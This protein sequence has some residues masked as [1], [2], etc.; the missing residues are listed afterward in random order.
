LST[1]TLARILDQTLLCGA[2]MM[3]HQK[4]DSDRP[5]GSAALSID[6]EW[7]IHPADVKQLV[8]DG[9][10]VLLDVR[11]PGEWE[12]ARI[13]GAILLP[14]SELPHRLHEIMHH[15]SKPVIVH[16]HHGM[17]SL[18]AVKWLRQQGFI[19]A[20]SMAAGIDGWSLWIDPTVP[21]Y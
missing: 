13:P 3:A 12:V 15:Q 16:C 20:K 4:P 14:L 19:H 7:E 21:R 11:T 6:P 10:V 8:R 17:R 1:N 9:N 2:A 18:R 5:A